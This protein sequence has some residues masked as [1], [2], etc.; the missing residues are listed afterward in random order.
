MVG[1]PKTLVSLPP[2]VFALLSEF[3]LASDLRRLQIALG[4]RNGG[5]SMQSP[6]R[7][8]FEMSCLDPFPFWAYD[9]PHLHTLQVSARYNDDIFPLALEGRFT[10]PSTPLPS[11]TTLVLE[12]QHAAPALFGI[13]KPLPL[14]DLFPELTYLEVTTIRTPSNLRFDQLPRFLKTL[15]LS[16]PFKTPVLAEQLSKLPLTIETL[17]LNGLTFGTPE[18]VQA[19]ITLPPNLKTLF[20]GMIYKPEILARLPAT[21]TEFSSEVPFAGFNPRFEVRTSWIPAE[22]RILRLHN[23]FCILTLDKHLPHHL[24]EFEATSIDLQD[25]NGRPFPPDTTTETV[26]ALIGP[27]CSLAVTV[28][29]AQDPLVLSIFD[30]LTKLSWS[31]GPLPTTLDHLRSFEHIPGQSLSVP[32]ALLP[33]TLTNLNIHIIHQIHWELI[34]KFKSL[35]RFKVAGGH[36]PAPTAVWQAIGPSLRE[37]EAPLDVFGDLSDLRL[38][39]SLEIL[40][41]DNVNSLMPFFPNL[42]ASLKNLQLRLVQSH[43]RAAPDDD[44]WQC[45][46]RLSKLNEIKLILINCWPSN[47]NAILRRLPKSLKSFVLNGKISA[48]PPPSERKAQILDFRLLPPRLLSLGIYSNTTEC[49]AVW[50]GLPQT[51]TS[52]TLFGIMVPFDPRSVQFP[53]RLISI[54]ASEATGPTGNSLSIKEL[55]ML[56]KTE[57]SA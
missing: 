30:H 47:C 32:L 18:D 19:E 54:T 55:A 13:E 2:V 26:K 41:M 33:A 5:K 10:V 17:K 8:A 21:L 38:F 28:Q 34:S 31:S 39:S 4:E 56:K 49:D 12:F 23:A 7:L 51:L 6:S 44:W 15:S 11:L 46:E 57:E 25:A 37:L 53:P 36:H 50:H 52:L 42:P 24:K 22:L 9:S 16:W 27:N 29:Y 35:N 20:F 43:S 48:S 45:M 14:S 40:N 1:P 3:V